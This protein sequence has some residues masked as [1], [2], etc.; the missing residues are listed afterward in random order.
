MLDIFMEEVEIILGV[1]VCYVFMD[2]FFVEG[3]DNLLLDVL[4]NNVILEID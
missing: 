4:E 3:E 1:V 2:V